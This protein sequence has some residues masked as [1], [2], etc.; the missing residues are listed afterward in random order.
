MAER[1]IAAECWYCGLGGQRSRGVEG[2]KDLGFFGTGT[3]RCQMPRV[4]ESEQDQ[5]K[6]LFLFIEY[7]PVAVNLQN[8]SQLQELSCFHINNQTKQ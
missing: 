7:N 1:Q 3:V 6:A 5:S 8:G 2:W 4:S